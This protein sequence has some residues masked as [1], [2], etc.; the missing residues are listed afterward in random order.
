MGTHSTSFTADILFTNHEEYYSA[1]QS[2][3]LKSS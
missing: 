1:C 2:S 3:Y